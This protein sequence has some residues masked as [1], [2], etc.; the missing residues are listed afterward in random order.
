MLLLGNLYL[1][2]TVE[3]VLSMSNE[4][5]DTKKIQNEKMGLDQG[6]N[7]T[8][9]QKEKYIQDG[10]HHTDD[11]FIR[12]LKMNEKLIKIFFLD[13]LTDKTSLETNIIKPLID[14]TL[15]DLKHVI[16]SAKLVTTT[17]LDIAIEMIP[18]GYCVIM[19]DLSDTLLLVPFP[20]EHSGRIEPENERIIRG[21]HQGFG[22]NISENIQFIRE[23]ISSSKLTITLSTIGE[24]SNSKYAL[25]YLYDITDPEILKKIENRISYIQTDSIQAPGGFEEYIQDNTYSPFPQ[26]LNTERVDRVVSNLTEG[27]VALIMDGSP[28]A[29]IFPVT[30]FSFFQ[31]AEDYNSRTTISSF[32]RMIRIFSFITTVC[33]PAFYIALISFN[34]EII[35][36]E[37]VFSIKGSLE[38]VPFPPLIEAAIMQLT[39]ELLREA[40]I[41]L[42]NPIAQTIGIV[43]GLVIGTAV[44]EANFVSNTMVIV[45]AITAIS[46]FVIPSNELSTSSR[47]LGFP[48]MIGAALFGVF[49]IVIGLTII[50]I[51]MCKL[52]SLSHPYLYPLAPFDFS[53]LKDTIIRGPIWSMKVRPKDLN[54]QNRWKTSHARGWKKDEKSD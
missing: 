54:T 42:P 18:E 22:E 21:S 52:K 50:L 10:L 12:E 8:I 2:P 51:H 32:F 36:I 45:V 30:F 24:T 34:Y 19:E 35:P 31:T 33:L 28:T 13:S 29:L 38:F 25:I 16:T 49:G 17:N 27:R 26:F 46:S 23:R 53:A 5:Q 11:L 9:I 43:G 44:V 14:S 37:I 6:V 7:S 3:G 48:L 39:L 1:Y 47:I 20:N 40:A 41:R 15:N 4:N